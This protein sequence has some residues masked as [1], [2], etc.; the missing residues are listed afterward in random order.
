[1][2][3]NSNSSNNTLMIPTNTALVFPRIAPLSDRRVL[4]L[5]SEFTILPFPIGRQLFFISPSNPEGFN[6]S[7]KF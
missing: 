7:C 6:D 4:L 2:I 5:T 3:L 1:M